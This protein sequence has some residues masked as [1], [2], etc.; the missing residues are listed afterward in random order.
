[1]KQI[2]ILLLASIIT[3]FSTYATASMN[4]TPI[5]TYLLSETSNS[6]QALTFVNNTSF[7]IPDGSNDGPGIVISE[8][9]VEGATTS[10]TKVTITLNI[11]HQLTADLTIKLI[12]PF[13]SSIV[14]GDVNIYYI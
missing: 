7:P 10:I 11:W 1:M 3:L 5:I 2:K 4:M 8:I 14:L 13:G 6:S 12:S 9:Y